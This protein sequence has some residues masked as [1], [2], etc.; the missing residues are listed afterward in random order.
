MKTMSPRRPSLLLGSQRSAADFPRRATGFRTFAARAGDT[1]ADRL[2]AFEDVSMFFRPGRGM[3]SSVDMDMT[4]QGDQ[5][6]LKNFTNKPDLAI[7]E[8]LCMFCKIHER[9]HLRFQYGGPIWR[10][11]WALNSEEST[12][13]VSIL[14]HLLYPTPGLCYYS[15]PTLSGEILLD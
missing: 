13:K 4:G 10:M 7:L 8:P 15:C 3:R 1:R 14:A 11:R 2:H 9:F 12:L 6:T 5:D